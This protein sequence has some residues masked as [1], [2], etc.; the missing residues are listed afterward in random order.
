[1]NNDRELLALAAKAHG[2]LLYVED[3]NSCYVEDMNSWIHVDAQGNRGA[4]W[5]PRGDDGDSRRLQVACRIALAPFS[6]AMVAQHFESGR[7][8]AER[9]DAHGG[10]SCAAA[11]LAVLRAAA[12]IGRA[13]P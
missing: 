8:W 12:E 3:M 6:D 5:N 11:R 2:G 13:M 7:S 9:Y 4:W 1:M 10:D